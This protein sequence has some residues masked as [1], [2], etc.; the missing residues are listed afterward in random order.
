[1]NP[2][3]NAL[4]ILGAG[5]SIV[6]AQESISLEQVLA[7]VR[8]S[9]PT[10]EA[11][12]TRWE[13]MQWRVPQERAWADPM[14]GLDL[15]RMGSTRLEDITDAEWMI[16]QEV[17]VSGKNRSRARIAESEARAVFQEYRRTELDLV[18]RAKVSYYRLANAHAQLAINSRNRTLLSDLAE[19]S[20][21]K[22]ETGTGT[23]SDLLLSQTELLRLTETRFNLQ[24]DV[25]EQESAL[26]V[27]MN[28]NARSALGRPA[29]LTYVALPLSRER[30]EALAQARRP[31]IALAAA[32]I[33]TTGAQLQLA[34]RQWIPDPQLRL[35]ARQYS[36]SAK[37]IQE[38]DTGIFFNV[39]WVN[40]RKYAAGIAEARKNIA[41]AEGGFSAAVNEMRGLLRDQLQRIDT[42]G[43][44]YQL[45]RNN[46]LPLAQ[47]TVEST[48]INYEADKVGFPELITARRTLQEMESA[49]AEHLANYRI[50]LAELEA[51]VGGREVRTIG[52]YK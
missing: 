6:A 37:V 16:S 30:L 22:Y 19:I 23:Q 29:A 1:M 50:A 31:E 15:E 48:R 5:A 9:N 52:E 35:E 42:S 43:R 2:L 45:F 11:A 49:M 17:P 27:L 39:P 3:F 28:R 34:R 26:N 51:L 4:L 44:N 13:A 46:L 41:S 10:L 14:A 20:R 40:Y 47:Q 36:G 18:N 24:R 12:R 32:R 21:V 25:A 38:Y 33:Q 7:E 8:R